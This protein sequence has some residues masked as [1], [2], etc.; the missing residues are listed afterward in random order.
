MS[1]CCCR[2]SV[3]QYW[4]N[5]A[6]TECTTYLV[7]CMLRSAHVCVAPSDTH[8]QNTQRNVRR[9]DFMQ[10][11]FDIN[12]NNGNMAY[13]ND[14]TNLLTISSDYESDWRSERL[15]SVLTI[16]IRMTSRYCFQSN[17]SSD[18]YSAA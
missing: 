1:V 14:Y 6:A 17:Q 4:R 15:K 12:L 11:E 8:G 5:K 3:K 7:T 13:V 16:I 10:T 2:N 18:E 9:N